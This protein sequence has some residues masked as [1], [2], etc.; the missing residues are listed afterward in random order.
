MMLK[1]CSFNVKNNF[2]KHKNK[3]DNIIDFINKYKISVLGVQEYIFN[4]SRKFNLEGYRCVGSGRF[5]QRKHVYNETN[6]IITN[7]N[8]LKF[9]TYRLPWFFT[10][11]PRIMTCA[12]V[13]YKTDNILIIN[14]HLDYLHRISQ[15]RQLNYILNYIKHKSKDYKIVLM[16]DFNLSIKS[17]LFNKFINDI[18]N[19]DISRVNIDEKTF[20]LLPHAIDHIFISNSFKLKLYKVINDQ[21]YDI[22]DHY[23]I[24]IEID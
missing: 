5:K 19:Y 18:K 16:G 1:I 10:S 8:V 13:K 17:E 9:K 21:K 14:T 12:L 2:I 3:T 24:Y 15:K 20:K 6:S 4:E 22:S 7:C 23:P 11:L